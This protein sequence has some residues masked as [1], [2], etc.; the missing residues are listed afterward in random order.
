MK[1][2]WIIIVY[3]AVGLVACAVWNV[4]DEKR[5]CRDVSPI[6]WEVDHHYETVFIWP[7]YL[8]ILIAEAIYFVIYLAVEALVDLIW[9]R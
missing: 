2:L 9:R 7:I 8:I 4:I 6:T 5:G 1:T 3:L